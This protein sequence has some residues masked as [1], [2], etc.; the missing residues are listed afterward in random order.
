[1]PSRSPLAPLTVSLALL[2]T[3]CGGDAKKTDAKADVKVDVK[4]ATPPEDVKHDPG[5]SL[6]KA[7]TAIDLAG[8]VPPEASAVFFAVDGALIPLACYLADKKKL[9]GGKDCLKVV[10]QGDEVYLKSNSAE[11]LDKIGAPKAALCE[12]GGGGTPTSLSVPAVDAGAPFDYAV[13][14]KS[15]A[16][17][18]VLMPEDSWGEKKPNLAAE[19]LAALTLLA[20][21]EGE[22]STRQL[23]SQD[24]D[25]DGAADKIASIYQV[26]PKDSERFSFSGVFVQFA[27]APGTWTLVESNKN[28]T[29]TYTVRAA[30]DLDGDRNHELW[31]NSVS[32]DGAG[33]DRI[34]QVTKT[35]ATGLGKWSCGG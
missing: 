24:L 15:L 25:G 13:A 27:S 14:P 17:Q 16:R 4:A 18:V 2:L 28:D 9:A 12:V 20:K 35:G 22:L 33:G 5:T 26:N 19:D 7:V 8:P 32:T 6:D 1:M 31:I 30:L 34:Y 3:A 23:A 11:N 29:L 10:K 21:V